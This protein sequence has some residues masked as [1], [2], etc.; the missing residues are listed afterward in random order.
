M[1][2]NTEI[3]INFAASSSLP[4]NDP[5]GHCR[6]LLDMQ[7]KITILSLLLEAPKGSKTDARANLCNRIK[8]NISWAKATSNAHQM[9]QQDEDFDASG[10]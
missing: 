6:R 7:A 8:E 10:P 2:T 9:E 1:T 3:T 4:S 5:Q